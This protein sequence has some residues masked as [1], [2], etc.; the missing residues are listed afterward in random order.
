[1]F[2][3]FTDPSPTAAH[4]MALQT[5]QNMGTNSQ[6]LAHDVEKVCSWCYKGSNCSLS[7]PDLALLLQLFQARPI[8]GRSALV[9]NL[10][11]KRVRECSLKA[12][13][14]AY[15]YYMPHGPWIRVWIRFGYDPRADP[16]SRIYQVSLTLVVYR[17]YIP[18]PFF[19]RSI[20][21]LL[22]RGTTFTQERLRPCP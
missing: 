20:Q 14:P 2:V 17:S 11:W 7:W 15:A 5:V 9:H 19:V 13:L 1:M 4:P 21:F 6:R 12:I 16:A 18:D 8:W 10:R 22:L 3:S